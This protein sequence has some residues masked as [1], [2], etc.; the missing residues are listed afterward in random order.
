MKTKSAVT[1]SRRRPWTKKTQRMLS[2]DPATRLRG[3]SGE[4]T[5]GRR[6]RVATRAAVVLIGCL[7]SA[8]LWSVTPAAAANPT[9]DAEPPLTGTAA[10]PISAEDADRQAQL[11]LGEDQRLVDVRIAARSRVVT[12]PRLSYVVQTTGYPTLVLVARRAAYTFDDLRALA[13]QKFTIEPDGSYLLREHI[14]IDAGATLALAPGQPTT[15]RMASGRK[16]FVSIVSGG[17]RLRLLGSAAA[18]LTITSW[19]EAAAAPDTTVRDGRAYLLAQGQLV[20]RHTKVTDLGFWSGRTGGLALEG[21]QAGGGGAEVSEVAP[22]AGSESSSSNRQAQVLPA[23]PQATSTSSDDQITGEISDSEIDGNAF[24]VFITGSSG[25]S[26]R[27]VVI[28]DSL[29][30]GLVLHRNVTTARVEQVRVER[31]GADGV[32][33][34]RGVE[35]AVLSQLTSSGNGGDGVSITGTPLATGPSPSGGSVRQFGNNVLS[36]SLIKNNG[37]AGI[38]VIGGHD[39]R[40]IG[41]SIEGGHQGIL[42]TRGAS[43][44]VIEANR[45]VGAQANG[46]QVRGTGTVEVAGNS[47]RG[48]PTGIHVA[49]ADVEATDNTVAGATLHAVS[50]VGAIRGSSV[51]NNTLSGSGSSAIDLSRISDD[52]EPELQAN[53]TNGW[54][55]V[56]TKDGLISTLTHPLTLIWLAIAVL[57][58]SSTVLRRRRRNLTGTPYLEVPAHSTAF[59]SIRQDQERAIEALIALESGFSATTARAPVSPFDETLPAGLALR[60]GTRI[61]RTGH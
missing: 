61:H 42:V 7:I 24:G 60:G 48:M 20:V 37:G 22:A 54:Q 5:V 58:V 9:P 34:T 45:V 35:A 27:N 15:I 39:V 53:D 11:V 52:T 29:V 31:S 26:V 50:L 44:V 10:G 17:G 30:Y 41:N 40:M 1:P 8:N 19:D 14:L 59:T 32:V 57:V 18:P 3:R 56:I 49:D 46:I 13:P 6:A 25:I 43:D 51:R 23:G 38:R 36:A 4:Q 47:V 16:G 12:F 33:I 28:L 2:H 55:R 21:V